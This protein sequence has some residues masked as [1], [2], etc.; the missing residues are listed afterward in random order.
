MGGRK[1]I[2]VCH[3]VVQVCLQILVLEI[4]RC[5]SRMMQ[6]SRKCWWKLNFVVDLKIACYNIQFGV[7]AYYN[8]QF[9]VLKF[10]G[11]VQHAIL[12]WLMQRLSKPPILILH[13]IFLL[14]GILDLL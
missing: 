7:L 1:Q 12:I 3:V 11:S 5:Y 8:I 14:N 4:L 6:Y 2:E 13:Q 10:G 9:G